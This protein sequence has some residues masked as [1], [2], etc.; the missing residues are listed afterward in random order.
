MISDDDR[1]RILAAVD[2]RFDEQLA[3]TAQLVASPS[4]RGSEE[5]AQDLI[6]SRLQGFDLD[7]DRWTIGSSELEAHPGYGPSKIGRAHV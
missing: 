4:R 7:I 5:P 1:D 3:A 2:A 6:E